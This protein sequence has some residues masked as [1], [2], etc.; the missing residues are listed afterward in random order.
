M[1]EV[2]NQEPEEK[3]PGL[4]VPEV[5]A[6]PWH[7]G[8]VLFLFL[9][10]FALQILLVTVFCLFSA[11]QTP[12]PVSSVTTEHPVSR[13]M[14]QAREHD[15][16]GWVLLVTFM[17]VVVITPIAE[18]FLFRLVL[19]SCL[20][21]GLRAFFQKFSVLVAHAFSCIVSITL[22][23]LFFASLHGGQHQTQSVER[24][25]AT[26]QGMTV[27]NFLTLC[28]GVSYLVG[29]RRANMSDL[30]LVR[31]GLYADLVLG[32]KIALPVMPVIFLFNILLR[33]IFPESGTD[34]IPI[35][36]LSIALGIIFFTT[37]RIL[38]CIT[39]HACLNGFSYCCMLALSHFV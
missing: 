37:G 22:V 27:A 19:Q 13:L 4:T 23:S 1:L 9:L 3:E 17:G 32:C 14:L 12:A 10:W 5:R 26:I 21:S 39:L 38:P 20:Q 15:Q 25:F 36:F 31:N 29:I 2:R 8:D 16:V 6:V 28:I 30:G 11:P 33:L 34:Q 18:E 7:G 24:L 35:F